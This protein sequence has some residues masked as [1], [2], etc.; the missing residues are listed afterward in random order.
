MSYGM[1]FSAGRGRA[2]LRRVASR[3]RR[4]GAWRRRSVC[5]HAIFRSLVGLGCRKA[6][7]G[8]RGGAMAAA[9]VL[10]EDL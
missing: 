3:P 9:L 10:V 1:V 2:R 4:G 5:S 8:C 7:K 6:R